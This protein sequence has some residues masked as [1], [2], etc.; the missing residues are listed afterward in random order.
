MIT[1]NILQLIQDTMFQMK[2]E[3]IIQDQIMSLVVLISLN[4]LKIN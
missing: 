4:Q 2:A 1:T 3:M